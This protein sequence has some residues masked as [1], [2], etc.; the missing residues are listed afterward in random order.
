MATFTKFDSFSQELAQGAHQFHAA[1]HTIKVYLT[2]ATPSVSADFVRT[3]LAEIA[4]GNGY[5]TGGKDTQNDVSRTG[6]VTTVTGIDMVWTGGPASMAQF[7]YAVMYNSS[8]S[9]KLIGYWDYNSG[10]T[11]GVGETFTV[12][13]ASSVI[14]YS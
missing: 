5:T 2:N 6:G 11:L 3:D 12:D 7:R 14:T 10:L 1:G 9:D 13:F 4:N 8:S